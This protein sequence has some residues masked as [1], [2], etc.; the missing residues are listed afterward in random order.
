MQMPCLSN[1][2]TLI[3]A[4]LLTVCSASYLDQCDLTHQLIGTAI[5]SGGPFDLT[6]KHGVAIVAG[7]ASTDITLEFNSAGGSESLGLDGAIK[8]I[9]SASK[10]ITSIAIM[11]LVEDPEL[12]LSLD[13]PIHKY[14]E[15]WT[16]DGNDPRSGVTLRHLLSQTAG[17]GVSP[18]SP[19]GFMGADECVISSRVD[20]FS[21]KTLHPGPFSQ[22]DCAKQ[23]YSSAYG[24]I[25]GPT[26]HSDVNPEDVRPGSHFYYA[27][28]NFVLALHLAEVV[29]GM[30]TPEIFR[31]RVGDV[32]GLSKSCQFPEV[33]RVL[34]GA[35]MLECST[36]DLGNILRAYYNRELLGDSTAREMQ[37][38]QTMLMRAPVPEF[39]RTP[40]VG[41]GWEA[42]L[43]NGAVHYGLGMWV[44]CSNTKC[45]GDPVLVHSAGF[46]G[47]FPFV[48]LNS[49]YWGVIGREGDNLPHSMGQTATMASVPDLMQK[50][51]KLYDACPRVDH[52]L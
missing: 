14:L 36:R 49:G 33:A 51:P 8:P 39:H 31:R 21:S 50:I 1:A 23:L 3:A 17:F 16:A 4:T 38:P 42:L 44:I 43:R 28:A 15:W 11:T 22:E 6:T 47:V 41:H 24:H 20:P 30:R 46:D 26:G 19:Y 29:T 7:K 5:S 37:A 45:E 2:L 13:D 35:G 27:S 10:M 9:Q 40:Y 12:A 32:L 34:D 48:D 52:E 25:S 18:S